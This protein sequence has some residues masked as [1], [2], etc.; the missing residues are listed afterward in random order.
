MRWYPL[1]LFGLLI[2]LQ[3]QIWVDPQGIAHVFSLERA[4]EAQMAENKVLTSR[5]RESEAELLDLRNGTSAVDERARF[6]L[7]MIG[8]KETFYQIA[9]ADP[10]NLELIEKLRRSVEPKDSK[11]P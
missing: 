11:N 9:P 1:F 6:D 10:E 2:Y 4:I 5:N 3:H 8:A 7:G